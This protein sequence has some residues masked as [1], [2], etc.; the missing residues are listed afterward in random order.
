MP[1][2]QF[3]EVY[4]TTATILNWNPILK[5]E[6]AKEIVIDAFRYTV[7]NGQS[8]ILA[9]VIMDNHFHLIWQ[10]QEPYTLSWV[11]A[12]ML[13]FTA[14]QIIN[15]H[16]LNQTLDLLSPHIVRKK[17]RF[18]QIW[19]RRPMS[20]PIFTQHVL[21]QK[22]NYLHSNLAK[23]GLSDVDYKY[24]SASYYATGIKNWDFLE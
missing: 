18:Y 6:Y 13:K 15:Y 24:S 12:N 7:T 11:R 22:T 14:Q 17:D 20:I 16:L 9:F 23:K 21:N 2:H 1:L 19:Q 4:F 5:Y 8:K 10:I 3:H